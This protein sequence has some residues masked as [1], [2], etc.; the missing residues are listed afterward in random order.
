MK[1]MK[2]DA[3]AFISYAH[4]DN[5]E[6]AAGHPGWVTN[7][8]RALAIRLAQLLGTESRVWWDQK[9]RGNDLLDATFV[10]RLQHV[11][12]LV[13]VISPRY[14]KSEWCRKEIRSSA[15]P[16]KRRAAF[17]CTRHPHLQGA[18]DS[19]PARQHPPS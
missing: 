10:E 17:A 18:E 2:F 1:V 5:V 8:Q 7:L 6:L 13:T 4:L 9:L 3:D 12:A 14:I 16:P 15:R 19:R 11:A